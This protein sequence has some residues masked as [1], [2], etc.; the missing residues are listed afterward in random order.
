MRK[1]VTLLLTAAAA[2]A[3][4]AGVARAST[5]ISP[6]DGWH[7]FSF[8]GTTANP[9]PQPFTSH[10][11]EAGDARGDRR[12]VPG[13]RL[14][15]VRQRRRHR[16]DVGAG[17]RSRLLVR[18]FDTGPR[19]R[20][21]RPGLQL[22][23]GDVAAGDPSITIAVA[24]SPYPASGGYIRIDSTHVDP[25]ALADRTSHS[26]RRAA[27]SATRLPRSSTSSF[28]RPDGERR[29]YRPPHPGRCHLDEVR[30]RASPRPSSRR[31]AFGARS[32]RCA[33]PSGARRGGSRP[34]TRPSRRPPAVR[35]VAAPAAS[36]RRGRA[37][38]GAGRRRCGEGR[39]RARRA[40]RDPAESRR[41]GPRRRR[42]A[43]RRPR[44][45][46]GFERLRC[47]RGL[48]SGRRRRV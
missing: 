13:R 34:R 31:R 14:H 2:A 46:P 3:L 20:H 7:S 36:T 45:R 28:R 23:M 18:G 22:R 42:L 19:D 37:P 38:P 26:P 39:R 9:G 40:G 41:R 21:G 25:A 8:T 35:A 47:G 16:R 6:G 15:R 10:D 33:A 24:Y 29:P 5:A 4:A 43:R 12:P 48:A 44:R 1:L 17:R 32:R 27:A 11:H 30:R